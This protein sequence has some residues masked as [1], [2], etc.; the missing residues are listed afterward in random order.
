MGNSK[1]LG[2]LLGASNHTDADRQAEDFYATDPKAVELLLKHYNEFQKDIWEPSCG[3]KHMANVLE[4]HGFNVRCSDIIERVPGIE[5][6]DF[7]NTNEK[8]KGDIIM[9]PPYSLATEF[10]THALSLINDG[11]KIA[12]FLKV[13][14]LESQS[15]EKLFKEY[16]PKYMYVSVNRMRCA[17]NGD[18]GGKQGENG[19]S[20]LCFCWYIWEK[21]YKGEPTI[22]WFNG[23]E[24]N[25]WFQNLKNTENK[26]F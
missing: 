13:Q 12:A 4:E 18:F 21:G 25:E 6:Q 3:M 19:G 9:N 1:T 16:P 11:S 8:W 26:L 22:R 7:L 17:K 5:I 20:A 15:R 2:L 23:K 10:V 14:F 24:D